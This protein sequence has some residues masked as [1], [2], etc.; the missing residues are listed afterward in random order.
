MSPKPPMSVWVVVSPHYGPVEAYPM[1]QKP[2]ADETGWSG[3]T[4]HR[5]DLHRPAKAK[6]RSSR[7]K[8]KGGGK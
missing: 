7:I 2:D 8:R 4:V 6:A 1:S 5:Y 3:A